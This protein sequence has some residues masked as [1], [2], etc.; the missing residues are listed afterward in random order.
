MLSI[1]IKKMREEKNNQ[2][3]FLDVNNLL[4]KETNLGWIVSELFNNTIIITTC[5]KKKKKKKGELSKSE[6]C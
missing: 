6:E 3:E 1:H 4:L 5:E 2:S